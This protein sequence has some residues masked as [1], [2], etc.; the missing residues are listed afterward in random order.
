VNAGYSPAQRR[1]MAEAARKGEP[2]RCPVCGGDLIRE[3][4]Q[5]R[6]DVPYVRRRLLLFCPACRR[7]AAVDMTHG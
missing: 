7:A 2:L 3:E 6:R 4:V 5:P 1:A